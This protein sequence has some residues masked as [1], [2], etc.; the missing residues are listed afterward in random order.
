MR[1]RNIKNLDE[2]LR[3]NSQF[4]VEDPA[5]HK[6][7][8]ARVFGNDNPIYLEIG[9]GKGQF[10]MKRAASCPS[11]NYIAIEGQ[12]NVAL[13]ALE[14]AQAEGMENLRIFIA[15]VH[16]LE[17]YFE[18]GELAGIYLNFSDPW[19]KARHFKRRLT[20][21]QR[22]LNYKKVLGRDGFVE[23]KTDNDGL[24]EFSLEEIQEAGLEITEVT[25]DLHSEEYESKDFTTEYEDRF[26]KAGK[27]INY[28]K[29]K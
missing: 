2:K 6:G 8:W 20:Y 26:S 16:D 17:D 23:F 10:I 13:R 24:F 7:K 4:L 5:Q 14:K 21:R 22:L 29:F 1:Q 9:C 12:S 19:P 3:Q 18:A 11:A 27:N 15:Y 25:G 28:V